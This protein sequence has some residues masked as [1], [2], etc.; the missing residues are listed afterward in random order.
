MQLL[1]GSLQVAVNLE[2]HLAYLLPLD[3]LDV[4]PEQLRV[5][6][7]P[8]P[9]PQFSFDTQYLRT[10]RMTSYAK[11]QDHHC[12]TSLS[13]I[14]ETRKCGADDIIHMMDDDI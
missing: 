2:V 1:E 11:C 4:D 6:K 5:W 12:R 8:L 7:E 14:S 10:L 3:P 9:S 13:D